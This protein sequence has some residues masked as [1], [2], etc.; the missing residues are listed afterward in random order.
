M[1]EKK[2]KSGNDY[3]KEK[4]A[5]L[6]NINKELH[7]TIDAQSKE[8]SELTAQLHNAKRECEEAQIT[9]M[10]YWNAMG[11]LRRWLFSIH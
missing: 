3:N 1:A 5:H 9:A 6:E 10:S 8:I 4:V 7:D 2:H 11:W